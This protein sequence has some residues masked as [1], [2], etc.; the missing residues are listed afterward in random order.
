MGGKLNHGGTELDFNG[1]KSSGDVILGDGDWGMVDFGGVAVFFQIV[2]KPGKAVGGGASLELQCWQIF[3]LAAHLGM[4][5][6]AFVTY[7]GIAKLQKLNVENRFVQIVSDQVTDT[8][9]LELVEEEEL[10]ETSKKAGG[11]EGKLA[12]KTKRRDEASQTRWRPCRK[13]RCKE[14][15]HKQCSERA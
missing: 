3:G 10:E 9:E 6:F 12:R 14:S 13:S 7:E 4:L 8:E 1:F 5:L 11:E 15:R 2:D